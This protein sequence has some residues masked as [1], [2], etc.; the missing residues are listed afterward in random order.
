MH[1]IFTLAPFH[2]MQIDGTTNMIAHDVGYQPECLLPRFNPP[3]RPRYRVGLW[4]N[5]GHNYLVPWITAW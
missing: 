1:F 2:M 5:F 3:P 4:A